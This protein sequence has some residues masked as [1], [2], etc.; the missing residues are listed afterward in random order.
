MQILAAASDRM[1]DVFLHAGYLSGSTE[2]VEKLGLDRPMAVT[3]NAVEMLNNL[4][5]PLFRSGEI[6]ASC[7]IQLVGVIGL[8]AVLAVAY[9]LRWPRRGLY[10]NA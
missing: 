2:I 7:F 9:L 8:V 6:R 4:G 5:D 1:L 10:D 3:L